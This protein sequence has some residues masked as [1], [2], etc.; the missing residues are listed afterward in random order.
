MRRSR[1]S[2]TAE[3]DSDAADN[4]VK[5]AAAILLRSAANTTRVCSF[6]GIAEDEYGP[7]G[8]SWYDP[9]V[10][11]FRLCV[12]ELTRWDTDC[13]GSAGWQRVCGEWIRCD[14]RDG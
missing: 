2:R 11:I 1:A 6:C 13:I 14:G 5:R 7:L 12:R 10:M 8:D 3:L 4:A 9:K